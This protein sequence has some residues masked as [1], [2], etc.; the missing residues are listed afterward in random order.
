MAFAAN[1]GGGLNESAR[2]RLIKLFRGGGYIDL[3][4]HRIRRES[5]NRTKPSLG[6]PQGAGHTDCERSVDRNCLLATRDD[7]RQANSGARRLEGRA[8]MTLAKQI[9]NLIIANIDKITPDFIPELNE[10]LK[11]QGYHIRA[12]QRGISGTL[13]TIERAQ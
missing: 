3:F 1:A 5:R 8:I 11:A 7:T 13:L 4:Q 6:P 9:A 10:A 12:E 2:P